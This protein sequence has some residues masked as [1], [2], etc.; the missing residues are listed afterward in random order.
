MQYPR[1]NDQLRAAIIAAGGLDAIHVLECEVSRD[2]AP[3]RGTYRDDLEAMAEIYG[4]DRCEDIPS[5]ARAAV[6]PYGPTS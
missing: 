4:V 5:A 1:S 2:S 3:D 6:L